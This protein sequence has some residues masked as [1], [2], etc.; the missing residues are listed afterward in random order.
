MWWNTGIH[1]GV[2]AV[3]NINEVCYVSSVIVSCLFLF[4]N[5]LQLLDPHRLYSK[6]AIKIRRLLQSDRSSQTV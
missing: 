6:S 4:I 5:L 1:M 3:L 2:V